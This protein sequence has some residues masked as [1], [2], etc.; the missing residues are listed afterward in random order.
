M[1]CSSAFRSFVLV[2]CVSAVVSRRPFAAMARYKDIA[3]RTELADALGVPLGALDLVVL[4]Q[5]CCKKDGCPFPAVAGNYNKCVE[6]GKSWFPSLK[7]QAGKPAENCRGHKLLGPQYQ[8][9][10]RGRT[11]PA[12]CCADKTCEGIGYSHQGNI[13]VSSK[14]FCNSLPEEASCF[15]AKAEA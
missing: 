4:E 13:R 12:C 8:R 5:N 3:S 6:H 1:F 14:E 9:V 2:F 11:A 7:T 15:W 10:Y